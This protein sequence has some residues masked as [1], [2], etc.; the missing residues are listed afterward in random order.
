MYIFPGSPKVQLCQYFTWMYIMF[1]SLK[2]LVDITYVKHPVFYNHSR[3]NEKIAWEREQ[4]V[5]KCNHWDRRHFV[6]SGDEKMT[7]CLPKKCHIFDVKWPFD[8][9]EKR[10]EI[11]T[12]HV[13]YMRIFFR[14]DQMLKR[15]DSSQRDIIYHLRLI[16]LLKM[17]MTNYV[18]DCSA[19][20]WIH[21]RPLSN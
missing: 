14:M 2:G 11:K 3:R 4:F 5:T 16:D 8:I 15:S 19:N 12:W 6:G 21:F 13:T 7:K 1:L 10:H 18:K 20:F 17:T 9:D